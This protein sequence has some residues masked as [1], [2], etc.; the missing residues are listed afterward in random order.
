MD[1]KRKKLRY[2]NLIAKRSGQVYGFFFYVPLFFIASFAGWIWEVSLYVIQDGKIINR[3]MLI[4]PW[5]PVYGCG[6]VMLTILL[7]RWEYKPVRIFF[8]SMFLC[9]L[10]EY[11]TS[12]TLERVWGLRFWD[13]SQQ[14]LN[15]NGR[16]CLMGTL[17]FGVGGWW[18]VCYV[19]PYLKMLYR[20]LV[21][22]EMGNKILQLACLVLLL[23]FVAD[24]VWAADFP[25]MG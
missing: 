24:A 17:L 18:L 1:E 4:G 12:Y 15:L 8:C 2:V 5:L 3:G 22:M 9:T 23:I 10:L 13:Y 11:L 7:K 19:A 21:K 14:F 25:N 20:K 6:A 16:I